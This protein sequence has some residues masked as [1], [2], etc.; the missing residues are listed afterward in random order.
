MD[1]ALFIIGFLLFVGSLVYLVV[2]L[3]KKSFTKKKFIGALASGFVLMIIGLSIPSST[4]TAS[5][6]RQAEKEKEKEKEPELTPEQIAA[7]E[8]AETDKKAKEEAESKAKAEEEAKK[9]AEQE[10][11]D[12]KLKQAVTKAL[13]KESNREGDKITKLTFDQETGNI[14]VNFKGDE[15]FT[16]NMTITGVQLDIKDTLKAIKTT[17]VAFNNIN[18]VVSYSMVDQYGNAEESKVIDLDYSKDTI[19]KINFDNFNTD[20]IYT[21]SDIVNFVH[22]AFVGKK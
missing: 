5:E 20:N 21:V 3:I 1:I 19:D 16:E 10:T 9:K 12:Y 7:N 4:E 13:G 6:P 14:L 17:G 22:Q 18:I 2:S 8:K 15:N 11:P